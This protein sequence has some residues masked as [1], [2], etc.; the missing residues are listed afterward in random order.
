MRRASRHQLTIGILAVTQ[1]ASWGSIYYAFAVLAADIERDLGLSPELIFG[2]FSWSLLVA[3]ML[4]TPIGALLD[5]FKGRR[6]MTGGSLWAALGL[7]LL[8]MAQ[9]AP[10]YLL[11]WTV[12]GMSMGAVLYE[13]AFATINREFASHARRSI[14]LLTLFGGL[15]STVFWPLTLML[16][17]EMGWR[18]TY[19]VYAA[20]HLFICAPLHALLPA[21]A[22][23]TERK[24]A[25]SGSHTLA[26]AVQHPAFWP[27]AA[28]FAAN[29][30]VFSALSVHL[31]PILQRMGHSAGTVV[32]LVALIGPMQV[33]GRM[34]EMTLARHASAQAV[35]VAIFMLLP[36]SLLLLALGGSQEV[37]VA[38]FCLLYG[39]SNGVVTIVRA[40]LPRTIFGPEHYGAISGAMAG[41]S[42]LC[43]AAGPLVL[44]WSVDASPSPATLIGALLSMSLV[45]LACYVFAIHARGMGKKIPPGVGVE[46]RP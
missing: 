26:Q 32:A 42:L 12:I 20:L 1:I 36:L 28:A 17:T 31:I 38:G 22:Q 33:A 37:I 2:G 21:R 4:S 11:A 10:V 18:E 6:V 34:A 13:A 9:S 27:L 3:G 16:N 29:S 8:G 24:M 40:T 7:A 39:V 46:K 15:A 35:G 45:A 41:P 43:K 19:L 25:A 44:A 23:Q 30:F 14:S 5:R